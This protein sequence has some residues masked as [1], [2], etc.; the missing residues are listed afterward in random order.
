MTE[1]GTQC[2]GPVDKMEVRQRLESMILK[3]FSSL[4]DS[5]TAILG[6]QM[7]QK[8]G[9]HGGCW[10]G[11]VSTLA[12]LRTGCHCSDMQHLLLWLCMS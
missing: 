6:Y 8:A 2:S 9:R 11:A 10:L 4:K 7:N 12:Q 5:V 1:G 3:A